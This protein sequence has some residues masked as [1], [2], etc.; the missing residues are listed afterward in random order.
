MCVSFYDFCQVFT[1][2]ITDC[3]KWSN[4]SYANL[5]DLLRKTNIS[6]PAIC[7]ISYSLCIQTK[8]FGQGK[9]DLQDKICFLY[10]CWCSASAKCIA[11]EFR[12]LWLW[13]LGGC[14]YLLAKNISLY[15]A[16]VPIWPKWQRTGGSNAIIIS[17]DLLVS[18][19]SC[20]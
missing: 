18:T 20:N 8:N 6:K 19:N 7:Q 15:Y 10:G 5:I 4:G 11:E 14:F 17:L 12:W 1:K 3:G 16:R 2:F 9:L 13:D